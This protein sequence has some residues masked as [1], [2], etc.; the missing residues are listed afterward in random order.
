MVLLRG[1][2]GGVDGSRSDR[3]DVA[4]SLRTPPPNDRTPSHWRIIPP[5]SSS[6]SS[7]RAPPSQRRFTFGGFSSPPPVPPPA[8]SGLPGLGVTKEGRPAMEDRGA[9]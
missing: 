3:L 9:A 6:S 5:P 4:G 2:W 7:S 8:S 1:V